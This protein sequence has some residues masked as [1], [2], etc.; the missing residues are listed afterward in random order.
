MLGRN[1][2]FASSRSSFHTPLEYMQSKIQVARD[3]LATPAPTTVML[4]DLENL[5]LQAPSS[6]VTELVQDNASG[7]TETETSSFSISTISPL[8]TKHDSFASRSNS[9]FQY[10]QHIMRQPIILLIL[11]TASYWLST[12]AVPLLN[13]YYMSQSTYKFPYPLCLLFIQLCVV[14]IILLS[15]NIISQALVSTRPDWEGGIGVTSRLTFDINTAKNFLPVSV[16]F[17]VAFST[18]IISL[19]YLPINLFELFRSPLVLVQLTLARYSN[20][21]QTYCVKIASACIVLTVG[22][23]LSNLSLPL[24]GF[25]YRGLLSGLVS[26]VSMPIMMSLVKEALPKAKHKHAYRVYHVWAG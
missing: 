13:K 6:R 15:W 22:S 25:N 7:F 10:S 24:I 19:E 8:L 23:A 2:P 12:S 17:F 9:P 21:S 1:R 18:S 4:A 14:E 26:C 11:T 3:S 16:A 5:E 20:S